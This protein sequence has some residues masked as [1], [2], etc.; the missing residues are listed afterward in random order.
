MRRTTPRRQRRR[1]K[2]D[3]CDRL[4]KRCGTIRTPFSRR[5]LRGEC[6]PA[7]DR[8][9]GR[10]RGEP[11]T[12]LFAAAALFIASSAA[13][14]A[15]AAQTPADITGLWDATVVAGGVEV[16]FRFEIASR[17]G[18]AAE[19]FFFEGDRRIGSTSGTFVNGVLKLEYEFLNTTLEAKLAGAQL[20][21]TYQNRR[22]GSRPQEIRDRKS[23]RLNSKSLAYL[24]CRLLLEK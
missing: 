22:A 20:V 11:V 6:R 1:R 5:C 19:G 13:F 24:V 3:A 14:P 21:G 9:G 15:R 2:A 16:P 17:G 10:K 8:I 12:K 7:G 18:D 23:T 4:L